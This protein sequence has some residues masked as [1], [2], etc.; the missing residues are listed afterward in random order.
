M[1]VASLVVLVVGVGGAA[2]RAEVLEHP[3]GVA[4]AV[5]VGGVVALVL[6]VA[7]EPAGH[8]HGRDHDVADR[9]TGG[10]LAAD[11]LE[12]RAELDQAHP[13]PG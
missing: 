10:E 9:A 11:L 3:L 4:A 8:R 2:Q 1:S 6:V 13:R 7:D 12:P 5:G